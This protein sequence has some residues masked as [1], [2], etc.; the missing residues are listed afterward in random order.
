MNYNNPFESTRL[1]LLAEQ[2]LKNNI[3]TRSILFIGDRE[4]SRLDL[5]TWQLDNDEN[6]DAINSSD[7]ELHMMGLQNTLLS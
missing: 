7:I 1:D 6:F 4:D 5:A 2:H 3:I